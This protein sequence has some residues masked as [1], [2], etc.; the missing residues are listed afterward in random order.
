MKKFVFKLEKIL[1]YRRQIV[2]EKKM[3]VLEANRVVRE[4]EE[5]LESARNEKLELLKK[6]NEEA[7]AKLNV[8]LLQNFSSFFSV[9]DRKI[10]YYKKEIDRAN[11]ELEK[12]KIEYIKAVQ[13]ERVLEKIK[14]KDKLNYDYELKKEEEKLIDS[15][16]S[17][18]NKEN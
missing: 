9:L 13:E 8:R 15:I 10:D 16:V 5:L 12:C 4:K 1:N 3:A 2:K 7:R 18:S 6:R 14:E 17:F 11:E